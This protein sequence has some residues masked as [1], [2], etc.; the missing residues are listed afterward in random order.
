M[1]S[2][3]VIV[4][5]GEGKRKKVHNLYLKRPAEQEVLQV[6]RDKSAINHKIGMDHH[7]VSNYGL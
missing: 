7:L 3:T 6:S 5:T 2:V 1:A 4:V